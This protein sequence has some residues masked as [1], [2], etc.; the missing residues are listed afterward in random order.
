MISPHRGIAAAPAEQEARDLKR[1]GFNACA[2][3]HVVEAGKTFFVPRDDCV[4]KIKHL[5]H[6]LGKADALRNINRIHK[7]GILNSGHGADVAPK[8]TLGCKEC[9]KKLRVKLAR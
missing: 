7:P 8:A 5:P 9:E 2:V 4:S 1:L 6:G 3:G